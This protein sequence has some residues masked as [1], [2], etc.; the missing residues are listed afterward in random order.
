MLSISEIFPFLH[1][2][3][4]IPQRCVVGRGVEGGGMHVEG[5]A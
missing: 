5:G 4:S 1:T 3:L 2:L